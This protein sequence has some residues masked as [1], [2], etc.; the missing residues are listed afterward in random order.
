[1]KKKVQSIPFLQALLF[2]LLLVPVLSYAQLSGSYTINPR[3][4]ASN[5]NY[6]NWESAVGDLI[7]GSR[8]DGG[9]AQGSGV[10]GAVVFTVYDTV[11]NVNL[12]IIAITGVS[13]T[14]SITFRSTRLDSSRCVL[15]NASST[16]ST[17]DYVIHLNG[18]D[19]LRF[20]GIGFE[21]TGTSTYCTVVQ[22]SND[23]D[24]NQFSQCYFRGRKMPSSSSLGFNYGIGSCLYFTGNADSTLV[25]KSRLLY[26]YNGIYGATSCSGNKFSYNKIDTSGCSGI[27]MTGQSGFLIENNQFNMGDFGANQ[28]HYVSY[29]M[30]IENSPSL[31][32]R[33]N[34][35]Q[36]LAVNGQVVRAV[37]LA[38]TTSTS[39]APSL[40][41][42]NFIFNGGGTGDC[43]GFAIYLCT[44]LNFHNN[45]VLINSSLSASAGYY[46]YPQYTNSYVRLVNNNFIN[47]GAG[48]AV[49][50]P[51]SNYGNID[52]MDYNNLFANG[53][54]IGQW[55]GTSYT[56]FSSWQSGTSLDVNSLNVDPGYISNADLHVANI[57]L[58]GKGFVSP[59]VPNDIDGDV[60]DVN[61]PDIGAD[62]FFPATRDVGISNIDSPSVF[63]AGVHPV[64]VRFQ[65]YGSDTVK[66]VSIQWQ[67]NSGSVST[68]NWSGVIA[69]G[70]SSNSVQVGTFNFASNTPYLFKVWTRLPNNANDQKTN[71]D[72][73]RITKLAGLTG[74]YS[75]GD[76]AGTDFKSINDAIT[77]ISSRGICGPVTFN[78]KHGVYNEQVTFTQ[79]PGMGS[80]N[81][82]RFKNVTKDSTKVVVT[83]PSTTATGNNNAAIQLRGADYVTFEGFTFQRTGTNPYGHVLHILNG[84]NNN[85]FQSCQFI[86]IRPLTS[87]V[88][89]I[90][91]WSDQSED[92]NNQFVGNLIKFGTYNMW[93]F[94]DVTAKESGTIIQGNTFDSAYSY[95]L[96]IV[97]NNQVKL[98]GNT[99][100]NVINPIGGNYQVQL[101]R[102]NGNI[103]VDRNYFGGINTENSLLLNRCISSLNNESVVSNNMFVRG[104]GKG[105]YLDSTQFIKVVHNSLYFYSSSSANAGLFTSG[106]YNSNIQLLN[107]NIVMEGGDAIYIASGSQ[108][109][110][111]NYNNYFTKGT[112]FV[113]WGSNINNI[114]S[115]RSAS[116]Q[117]SRSMSVLPYFTSSTDLHIKNPLLKGAGI[118]VAEVKKDFDGELRDTL[119]PDIGADE[120]LLSKNDASVIALLSPTG[121]ECAAN[122]PVKVIIRNLGKDTLKNVVLNWVV[123]GVT[124]T[125]FSWQGNLKNKAFDT[126]QIGTYNFANNAS[127]QFVFWS[128]S[129]NSQADGFP[130]NDTFRIN[131]S[132]QPLPLA[133]AGVNQTICQG[134]TVAIGPNSVSGFSYVWN[135][136]DAQTLYGNTSRVFVT[137]QYTTD[138]ELV[139]TNINLGCS[140]RDTV[141]I[142]V[143]PKPLINAGTDRSL[144]LGS[145]TQIG[146]ASQSGFTYQWRSIPSG[147]SSTTSN[148]IVSPNQTTRYIL[149]KTVIGT[150]CVATDT[151][152]I[153]VFGYPSPSIRGVAAPCLNSTQIYNTNMVTGH[154]YLWSVNG[155]NIVNGQNTN[156]IQVNWNTV[157]NKEVKVIETNTAGCKDTVSINVNIKPLPVARF[158]VN[159]VCLG[160]AC[161][162]KDSSENAVSYQ[163]TFGDGNNSIFQ[164]PTHTYTQLGT[165]TVRYAVESNDGCK[166]TTYGLVN[167]SDL[168]TAKFGYKKNDQLTFTFTDSSL[169]NGNTIVAWNWDFG[170]GNISNLQNPVHTYTS[171]VSY[172]VKLCVNTDKDC[173]S[174]I[175][176]V[177]AAV[178]ISNE[179]IE[180]GLQL[181]PNPNN[182]ICQLKST[183]IIESVEVLSIEGKVIMSIE[184]KQLLTEIQTLNFDSGV[185]QLRVTTENQTTIIKM[186]VNK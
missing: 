19:F 85:K 41:Y 118:R 98:I 132:V 6:Q 149:D 144:C 158:R 25:N 13:N 26:G 175:S 37:I 126:I 180:H 134:T 97:D 71:N 122:L 70:N 155:G 65:N 59:W 38:N 100:K 135:D 60:R 161:M 107:N 101:L 12:D 112:Q 28:G 31:I 109:S 77:G 72:T 69:P 133:N 92:N 136:L 62:E 108:V 96:N 178:G 11:Y 183:K 47:K 151:V 113:Y 84:S 27:Y 18:V 174:C 78:V 181:F 88:N 42:N 33:N 117:E 9:N 87:N 91:I 35:I 51:G 32:I 89:A 23:A 61:F 29:A 186:I 146:A 171:E 157:G 179:F 17:G 143:N 46:H 170:D 121:A 184:P 58:N 124:Q 74:N 160:Q 14:S 177:V 75:I 73:L 104:S 39:S 164:N 137:P 40:V 50:V 55:N 102:C 22:L 154:S 156:N 103:Q 76:T 10:S 67:I 93:Y 57:S 150:G 15:K 105:I 56:S 2:L 120:F 54:Y 140:R 148:P 99:F 165:Y 49:N 90:N 34:K 114:S 7:S 167:I 68:Y 123:S 129:P 79:L 115:L 130:W 176:K 63:C 145:S 81:P 106:I 44:Y 95:A 141:T 168:P 185:Y 86:G 159:D 163:W 153:S 169:E 66:Q 162:F 24:N 4:N 116:G 152:L 21:R 64:K 36:M 45:N 173:E 52:S 147:F 182:G 142:L 82:I 30:R 127:P 166:D 139:V 1:M 16:S 172:T 119:T 48:F 138:Y 3:Q 94:G 110:V 8:T 111:S 53:T 125:A 5:S 80:N 83:L 20:R 128:S 43:T 131:R